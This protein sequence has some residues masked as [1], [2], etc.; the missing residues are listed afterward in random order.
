MTKL[1]PHPWNFFSQLPL[2]II[3]ESFSFLSID[4]S[5]VFSSFSHFFFDDDVI[6]YKQRF[7]VRIV[8][9]YSC[10]LIE[11]FL[12]SI[13]L[14]PHVF[15]IFYFLLRPV[16][17]FRPLSSFLVLSRLFSSLLV[18]SRPSSFSTIF[19]SLVCSF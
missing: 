6:I 15:V 17:K 12:A 10:K 9:S 1:V 2:Q 3:G 5:P 16:S 18:L 7:I 14:F 4:F 19:E 8:D 13:F 11:Q